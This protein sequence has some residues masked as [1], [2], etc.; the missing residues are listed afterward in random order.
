MTGDPSAWMPGA[1]PLSFLDLLNVDDVAALRELGRSRHVKRGGWVFREGEM[2]SN[3]VLVVSGL[4]KVWCTADD[5]RE[6]VLAFRGPGHLLGELAVVDL[7]PRSANATAFVDSELRLV[8]ADEFRSYVG[9]RPAAAVAVLRTVVARLRAA[10]LRRVEFGSTDVAVRLVRRLLELA[11]EHGAPREGGGV[12][13]DLAITQEELAAM[14]GASR[15]A[16]TRA[17][18]SLREAGLV[19]T[20][21]REIAL[22][23]VALLRRRYGV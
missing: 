1:D 12:K 3:V 14:V 19:V 10:D 8:S 2:S 9:S 22:C 5:G 23:D 18:R 4:V 6:S 11:D 21:R 7:A 20:A 17:L 15:E 13:I 16:V